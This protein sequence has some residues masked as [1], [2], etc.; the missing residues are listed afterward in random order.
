M[1]ESSLVVNLKDEGEAGWSQKGGRQRSRAEAE[2]LAVEYE[3]SGLSQREFSKERGVPLKTLARYVARHRQ[4]G[5]PEKRRWVAIEVEKP[6]QG[7]CQLA[8]VLS[9]GRRVEVQRGFDVTTLCQLISAL[10]RV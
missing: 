2:Q 7:S 1:H 10:E 3:A 6:S 8:V 9:G 4:A 5:N